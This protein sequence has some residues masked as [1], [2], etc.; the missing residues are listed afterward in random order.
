LQDKSLQNAIPRDCAESQVDCCR[1]VIVQRLGR[2]VDIGADKTERRC[3]VDRCV[4]QPPHL[5]HNTRYHA[6][7]PGSYLLHVTPSSL[8]YWV[9]RS[10]IEESH[11]NSRSVRTALVSSAGQRNSPT[12]ISVSSVQLGSLRV[13]AISPSVASAYR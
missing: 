6:S 7:K 13:L 8:Y 12:H 3:I 10:S 9:L 2:L 5:Q 11:R 1:T 4:V